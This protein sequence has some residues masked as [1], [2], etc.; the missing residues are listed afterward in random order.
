MYEELLNFCSGKTVCIVGPSVLDTD[1][2]KFIDSHDI[3]VRLNNYKS[4]GD[5]YGKKN[6]IYFSTFDITYEIDTNF[7]YAILPFVMNNYIIDNT[8]YFNHNNVELMNIRKRNNK[9]KNTTFLEMN[10]DMDNLIYKKLIKN[11]KYRYSVGGITSC[12]FSLM[13]EDIKKLSLVG[14]TFNYKPYDIKY[15]SYYKCDNT[16]D[17][18]N[19][20]VA[21]IHWMKEDC[22][23]FLNIIRNFDNSQKLYIHDP[24]FR[25]YCDEQL[26]KKN[27]ILKN[28]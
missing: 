28:K 9:Y 24:E 11:K 19:N 7:K 4:L 8:H 3:V 10:D 22:D 18:F 20:V 15:V 27:I 26:S 2:S 16:K 6:D 14:L 13:L 25:N 23:Y 17:N 1:M 21:G 5:N 12:I